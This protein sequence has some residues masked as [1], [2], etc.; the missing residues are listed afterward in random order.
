MSFPDG[1]VPVGFVLTGDR[2]RAKAFYADVMGFRL[3]SED[4]FAA[5][6]DM[7]GLTVRLTDIAGHVAGPHTVLGWTVPDI[8][9]AVRELAGKG[10][11]FLVYEG[12]GQDAD[13]IWTSPDGAVRVAW[14]ADPDGNNLSLT[15]AS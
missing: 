1:A 13:G 5:V 9:A 8:R 15:E 4:G 3:L 12:F 6:F 11:T 14:F 7:G 2:A 10:V